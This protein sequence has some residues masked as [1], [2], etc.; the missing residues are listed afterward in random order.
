MRTE[1]TEHILEQMRSRGLTEEGARGVHQFPKSQSSAGHRRPK[2]EAPRGKK[3]VQ[4]HPLASGQ[5]GTRKQVPGR[6]NP[7]LLPPK[8]PGGS[9]RAPRA[10]VL[11]GPGGHAAL[12]TGRGGRE[13]PGRSR[14]GP[15]SPHSRQDA[16]NTVR[17]AGVP[18]SQRSPV[19][20]PEAG[21]AV[22]GHGHKGPRRIEAAHQAPH[23]QLVALER[24]AQPIPGGDALHGPGRSGARARA[25]ARAVGRGGGV[26]EGP[27]RER[28]LQG[29]GALTP[30]EPERQCGRAAGKGRAGRA[31]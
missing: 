26:R 22:P 17:G 3:F 24:A 31:E 19:R 11:S 13:R 23:V 6:P 2:T 18:G 28:D 7:L 9:H 1:T 15:L 29:R 14:E 10:P 27:R 16:C 4:G 30:E 20:H 12:S 5:V 21:G 8:R 25:R